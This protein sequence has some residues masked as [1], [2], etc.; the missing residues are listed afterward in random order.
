MWSEP[1]LHVDLD[2][3][4]VEAERL[5]E[6]GL[7]VP[8]GRL[9]I[10]A[11]FGAATA[12]ADVIGKTHRGER[13]GVRFEL[14]PLPHPSGASTWWK[15]EP[16][17]TLLARALGLIEKHPAWQAILARAPPAYPPPTFPT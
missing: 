1:I 7:V 13:A 6:P 5:L 11:F 10:D 9:A 4:F 16:G 17:A 15:T 2:A 14:I 12:L 3:F 8:I